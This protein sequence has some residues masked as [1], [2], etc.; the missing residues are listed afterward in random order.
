MVALALE[1]GVDGWFLNIEA[2]LPDDGSSAVSAAADSTAAD[3]AAHPSAPAPAPAPACASVVRMCAFLSYL[4]SA[5][6]AAVPGSQVLWY[7]SVR[8]RDGCVQWQS[9]LNEHNACFF[10]ACDG[11]FTDYHWKA[12]DPRLSAQYAER[13]AREKVDVFTGIDLFGRGTFGGGGLDSHTAMEVISKAGTSTAL[14][15]P[16]WAYEGEGRLQ[17]GGWEAFLQCEHQLWLGELPM[18]GEHTIH[19]A[20]GMRRSDA[21]GLAVVILFFCFFV[22]VFC[23]CFFFKWLTSLC[24]FCCFSSRTC[25][26]RITARRRGVIAQRA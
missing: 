1:Y 21:R 10:D 4:T 26:N 7:D 22:L 12:E 18:R 11:I 5:M 17:A 19:R 8:A 13:H 14:F 25:H 24:C 2:P 20:R 9:V 15:A 3:P 23:F 6:H 16:A